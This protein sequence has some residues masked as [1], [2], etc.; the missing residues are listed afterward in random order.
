M[1]RTSS[2]T[3]FSPVEDQRLFTAHPISGPKEPVEVFFRKTEKTHLNSAAGAKVFITDVYT[4][5]LLEAERPCRR[6]TRR[7]SRVS[8][9]YLQF[10]PGV[11]VAELWE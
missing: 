4:E 8:D 11:S 5:G 6:G 10:T 1:E 9:D 3:D 7:I 2:R